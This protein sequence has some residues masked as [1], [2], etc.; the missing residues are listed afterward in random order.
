MKRTFSKDVYGFYL[1][2]LVGYSNTPI[3]GR[4]I[5]FG[6]GP[7]LWSWQIGEHK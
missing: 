6:I 4:C 1:L 5:W 7:Y 2:P 3:E